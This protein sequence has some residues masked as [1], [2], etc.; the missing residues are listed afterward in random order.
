MSTSVLELKLDL[1]PFLKCLCQTQ[2]ALGGWQRLVGNSIFKQQ[3]QRNT[4][5]LRRSL[6]T[7]VN[8]TKG[9]VDEQ[10]PILTKQQVSIF[11]RL[12]QGTWQAT[13]HYGK[14][15]S[16]QLL[17]LAKRYQVILL[18]LDLPFT[19]LLNNGEFLHCNAGGFQMSSRSVIKWK[20]R[21]K[22]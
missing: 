7:R 11:Y 3:Q 1:L 5:E 12:N 19:L 17:K 6:T 16:I 10:T 14:N 9:E 8:W 4:K 18:K 13:L 2:H 15:T 20:A 21:E 22:L